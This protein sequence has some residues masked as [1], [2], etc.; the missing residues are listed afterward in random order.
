MKVELIKRVFSRA[1]SIMLW[2]RPPPEDVSSNLGVILST[3][4]SFFPVSGNLLDSTTVVD[5][6]GGNISVKVMGSAVDE[7]ET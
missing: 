4:F 7:E 3:T 5:E 2:K 6:V 1:K